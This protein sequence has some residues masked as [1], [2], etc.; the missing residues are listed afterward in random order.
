M[1]EVVEIENG[2]HKQLILWN[3]LFPTKPLQIGQKV[4]VSDTNEFA[5]EW[6]EEYVMTGISI[7]YYKELD[8]TIA[9]T[10]AEAG[11]DGWKVCDLIP[12]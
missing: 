2:I 9:A 12:I 3:L 8:I 10:L 4:K 5:D 11:S 7:N 1:L 6:N